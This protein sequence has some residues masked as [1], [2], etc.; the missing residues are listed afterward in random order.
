MDGAA[1]GMV[2]TGAAIIG[3][4][5][6]AI[7]TFDPR[8][9]PPETHWLPVPLPPNPMDDEPHVLVHLGSS[10]R[11]NPTRYEHFHDYHGA[12]IRQRALARHGTPTVILHVAS[13]TLR[14]DLERL[15]EPWRRMMF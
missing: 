2:L 12:V 6:A 9:P 5:F 13:G 14:L 4:V 7:H 3:A 8:V 10:G 15:T 1:L 11:P